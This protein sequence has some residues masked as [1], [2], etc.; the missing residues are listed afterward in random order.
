MFVAETRPPRF[1]RMAGAG[2][3]NIIADPPSVEVG[4]HAPVEV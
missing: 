4:K 3:T 2:A 1:A